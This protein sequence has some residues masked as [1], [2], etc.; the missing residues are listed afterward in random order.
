M[1]RKNH[2]LRQKNC[3]KWRKWIENIEKKSLKRATKKNYDEKAKIEKNRRLGENLR[4]KFLEKGAKKL[5]K[6]QKTK[7]GEQKT[8]IEAKK[9]R[10]KLQ[11]K[12]YIEGKIHSRKKVKN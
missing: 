1:M 8:Q 10:K 3:S 5:R 2:R 6:K 9:L 4:K 11:N 12:S 7:N